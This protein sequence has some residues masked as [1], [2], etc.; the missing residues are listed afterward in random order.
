MA[1]PEVSVVVPAHERPARLARLLDALA[2]QTLP[3]E[4][5]EVVVVH[6]CVG[7]DSARL[8]AGH[9]LARAGVLRSVR[10]APG[11]GRP[12][13]QRNRGWREA[14]APLIAFTDD[15]CRPHEGWLASLLSAAQG[16][17]GAVVQGAT[18]PDPGEEHLLA[19]PLARS[20]HVDPPGP[21]GQ[22]CNVL[23]PRELLER[24]EGF[25][26]H[27]PAAAGEDTD[28]FLRA[29]EAGAAV[30]AAPK[31]LVWHAV[32]VPS[33]GEA[34]RG[35]GRWQHVAYVVKRHPQVREQLTLRVFWKPAHARL[36]LALAG[37]GLTRRRVAGVPA[38][39]ALAVPWLWSEGRAHGVR[40]LPGRL[41][42]DLGELAVAVRGAL[43]YRTPFL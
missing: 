4:R 20:L 25:A 40:A 34:L 11:T 5:F 37:L 17:P 32:T 3:P 41:V 2:A 36:L 28:L 15:D 24:L 12:S 26:E 39:A 18:R 6:D 33:L 29:R 9:D 19:R 1:A 43:R 10:L 31:A 42:V 27:L 16:V 30:A 7:E 14:A 8:L 13:V 21:Y 22:T 38:G 23:Y 35:L